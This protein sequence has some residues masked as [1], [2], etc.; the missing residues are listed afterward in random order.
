ML[1]AG[2]LPRKQDLALYNTR[3]KRDPALIDKLGKL[4][5]GKS[6]LYSTKLSKVNLDMLPELIRTAYTH[7]NTKYNS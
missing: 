3:F 4:K 5:T 6:C 7:M 1:L 2:F